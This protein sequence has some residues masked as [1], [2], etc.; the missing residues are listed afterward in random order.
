MAATVLPEMVVVEGDREAVV[1]LLVQQVRVAL[2]QAIIALI[3]P[4]VL[5][6]AVVAQGAHQ[7]QHPELPG[8]LVRVAVT[9][10]GVVAQVAALLLKVRQARAR[11]V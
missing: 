6:Q 7:V 2:V 3:R 5:V 10:V 8:M 4:T 1:V 11:P 9:V